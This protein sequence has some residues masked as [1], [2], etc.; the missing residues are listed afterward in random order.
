M[1]KHPWKSPQTIR[2]IRAHLEAGH[3][4]N[5]RYGR[6]LGIGLP[7]QTVLTDLVAPGG[8]STLS[9]QVI[10]TLNLR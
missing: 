4:D 10:M 7:S 2:R 5:I 3:Y 1:L 9:Y 8:Q 6:E